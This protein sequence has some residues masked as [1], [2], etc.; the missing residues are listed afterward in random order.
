MNIFEFAMKMELDGK[1]YYEEN[2]A[3]IDNPTL[4]NIL[5][6]LARD[7]QKH[8]N[9]FKAM[10]NNIPVENQDS[11]HTEILAKVKNI[12]ETLKADDSGFSFTE[13]IKSIWL[14]ARDIEKKAETF[15]REKINEVDGENNKNILRRIADEEHK[16]WILVENV[17]SFLDRPGQWLENAEWGNI[18][19]I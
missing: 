6:E 18:D 1:N 14:K 9:I 15:Y 12:F 3:T 10:R 2:A 17:I 4:K 19:D 13:D 8:Y 16:H 5:L 7:E 11:H